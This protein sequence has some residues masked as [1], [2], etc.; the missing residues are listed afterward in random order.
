MSETIIIESNR[1]IAYKQ[2]KRS[3]VNVDEKNANVVLPNNRWT[4]RLEAG[5]KIEVGDEI[6]VDAVMVNTRG[7][8]EET[9]EFSGASAVQDS[10]DV[11]DNKVLMRLQKY[12]T[13]RQQFNCNLP[14][15]YTIVNRGDTQ[16]TNYG[17]VDFENFDNFESAYPYRGIEGMYNV[18]TTTYAKVVTVG[19]NPTSRVFS[20]APQPLDDADTT[21]MY[22]G[23]DNFRGYGKNIDSPWNFKTTDIDFVVETGFNTPSKVGETL[24]AQLHQRQGI[25]NDWD[26]VSVRATT[27]KLDGT[28]LVIS[29]MAAITDQSYTT[30]PTSTGDIF[31]ARAEGNWQAA[32]GGELA[33]GAEG[34]N[35]NPIQGEDIHHRNLLCGNPYEYRNVFGWLNGR[36]RHRSSDTITLDNFDTVGMMTGYNAI[37]ADDVGNW[38]LNVVLTDTYDFWTNNGTDIFTFNN[39]TAVGATSPF[40]GTTTVGAMDFLVINNINTLF[41][42]NNVYNRDNLSDLTISWTDAEIPLRN[43]DY[44]QNATP[45]TT[46][47]TK[48]F[49]Q[50]LYYGRADDQAS[51]G[52]TGTKI[53]LPT[54]HYDKNTPADPTQSLNSYHQIN[55]KYTLV[56]E[57][58]QASWDSRNEVSYWSRYDTKFNQNNTNKDVLHLPVNTHF[59]LTDSKGRYYSQELS[60]DLNI[61]IIP[62][63]YK[64]SELVV[65]GGDIPNSLKDIPFCAFVS[66]QTLKP[67]SNVTQRLPLPF[68]GEFFGRSPSFYD[69]QLA[70]VVSTQK[71]FTTLTT[72]T[73]PVKTYPE[74][75]I[76]IN[77]RTYQYM[78]YCMIGADNPSISFDDTYGRFTVNGFHTSVRA[79]NGVFQSISAAQNEQAQTES[80]CAYSRDV[81]ICGT[82]GDTGEVLEYSA[83][84]QN[85]TRN[86]IISSQS[87]IAIQDMFLYTKGGQPITSSPLNPRTPINYEGSLFSKLG[88]QL[89]QL[90]PYYGRRQSNFNR[91]TY[92]QYLGTDSTFVDKYDTMVYPFTTDAYISAAD[93]LSMV[94]NARDYP[95]LNLGGNAPDQTIFINAV[96]D[97]LVAVNLP[98]KLDYSYLIIYSNI[99]QNTQFYGGG[100][101]Q[102]KIPAMAY[103]S[104][105]YSTGDFF[106]GQP[107]SWTYTADK[108]YII[109]EFDTNITLPNGLPAPIEN[110]SS[111]IYKIT[112]QKTMPPPLSSFIQ[113]KKK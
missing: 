42:T 93:Q 52:A 43:V 38:G 10:S 1:Q 67:A 21:R 33:A 92:N 26:E 19:T 49:Y 36:V 76:E 24:T 112:K 9:I 63:F 71:T 7:S 83:I 23:D 58:Q 39:D 57:A 50:N 75:D 22:L 14:L 68:K 105:N 89:E 30:V 85:L 54:T 91:G 60:K 4:T 65:N 41:V 104:R 81:A 31:R 20:K 47:L 51:C 25:P 44:R 11:V 77:T 18:T 90:V 27:V 106:F 56:R 34:A 66:A 35:Y 84:V 55:G 53:N 29:P 113:P 100:N 96:S 109:T 88:F 2:E 80:I 79:G 32:I 17:Y 8:P 94:T 74:G 62:V 16:A 5:V 15:Y 59:S 99:V 40:L 61:A 6:Q 37:N 70:K 13:N 87:G 98:S 12:I 69:N 97:S 110:N 45:L 82:A 103:V 101:G 73:T 107:T 28:T 72:D 102:Q 46:D 108:E 111:I 78:T 64:Q 86:P 48:Q 95:M 3:L